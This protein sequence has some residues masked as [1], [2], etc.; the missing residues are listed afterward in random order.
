MDFQNFLVL[1]TIL[2]LCH[3]YHIQL[4][5]HAVSIMRSKS[6][7]IENDSVIGWAKS[8]GILISKVKLG[9]NQFDD[10]GKMMQINLF[11]DLYV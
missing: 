4:R 3:T 7:N 6:H 5:S 9:F 10:R 8:K 2:S 1:L 11:H